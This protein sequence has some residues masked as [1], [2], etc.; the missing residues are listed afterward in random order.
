MGEIIKSTH[1]DQICKFSA[2]HTEHWVEI[3]EFVCLLAIVL[4]DLKKA[5]RRGHYCLHWALLDL[6][7]FVDILERTKMG[8]ALIIYADGIHILIPWENKRA[9]AFFTLFLRSY[10]WDKLNVA[11]LVRNFFFGQILALFLG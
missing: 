9:S 5:K 4:H 3:F 10:L 7:Y 6:I 2:L 8:D 1:N 11:K